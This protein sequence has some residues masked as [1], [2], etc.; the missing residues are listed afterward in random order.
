MPGWVIVPK[1][2]EFIVS[3][4]LKNANIRIFCLG[5]CVFVFV[6]VYVADFYSYPPPRGF[7]PPPRPAQGQVWAAP[8]DPPDLASGHF[9]WEFSLIQ[10]SR[11]GLFG[12]P[13]IHSWSW[14]R[15][16][17]ESI[18]FVRWLEARDGSLGGRSPSGIDQEVGFAGKARN[19]RPP[20]IYIYI[21]I[22]LH[23]E[24]AYG[25]TPPP[26][27]LWTKTVPNYV[28]RVNKIMPNQTKKHTKIE[29]MLL[30]MVFGSSC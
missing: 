24:D 14:P 6:L 27:L 22:Y 25:D 5:I 26:P 30:E 3:T 29:K 4:N 28:N 10:K 9:Q 16:L 2:S 12:M 11:G 20:Y 21:Y 15:R 19:Q 7:A 18:N 8:P 1:D 17:C 13:H 23:I